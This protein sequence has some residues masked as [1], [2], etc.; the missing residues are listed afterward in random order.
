MLFDSSSSLLLLALAL[1]VVVVVGA[2]FD[3]MFSVG[4]SWLVTVV[5]GV[6]LDAAVAVVV[7]LEG[8][9]G[10][11]RLLREAIMRAWMSEWTLLLSLAEA[12]GLGS[13]AFV[14]TGVSRGDAW[15]A[16]ASACSARRSSLPVFITKKKR[17]KKII[18]TKIVHQ[19]LYVSNL[20][21]SIT[22]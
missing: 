3:G 21:K 20:K 22:F 9:V 4:H 11:G 19:P 8:R 6:M 7:E 10:S 17:Q 16:C 5:D 13:S 14:I 2:F 15:L 18:V 1:A 12:S